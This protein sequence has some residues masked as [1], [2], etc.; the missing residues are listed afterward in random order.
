MQPTPYVFDD[1]ERVTLQSQPSVV[2]TFHAMTEGRRIELRRRVAAAAA[3]LRHIEAQ[4]AY[5]RQEYAKTDLAREQ[6]IAL[7]EE[8]MALDE[9]ADMVL[10]GNIHPIYV[11]WGVAGIEGLTIHGAPAIPATL[12]DGP[13]AVY[14]EVVA[15]LKDRMGLTDTQR[16]NSPSPTTSNAPAGGRT[17]ATI[18]LS[19]DETNSTPSA[20]A[21]VTTPQT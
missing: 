11:A 1:L 8:H 21:T 18:A 17:S 13:L 9:E 4:S 12:I 5:L 19:A 14:A 10:A 3:E 2:V 16:K 7:Y 6:R 20:T 15:L